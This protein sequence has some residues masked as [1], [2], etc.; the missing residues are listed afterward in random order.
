[1]PGLET[2]IH[3]PV[4]CGS[5]VG[6]GYRFAQP[7]RKR[8]MTTNA[9]VT[10]SDEDLVKTSGWIN[11]C[12]ID[13]IDGAR[14]DQIRGDGRPV[15][16]VGRGQNDISSANGS[17]KLEGKPICAHSRIGSVGGGKRKCGNLHRQ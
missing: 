14:G 9:N 5:S 8:Q 15:Q 12:L 16:K 17:R 10:L 2:H 7:L 4:I 13:K 6:F 1:M 3:F 11:G